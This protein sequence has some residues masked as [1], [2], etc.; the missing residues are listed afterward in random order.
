[1][2]CKSCALLAAILLLVTIVALPGQ[3][4]HTAALDR[5]SCNK[6]KTEQAALEKQGVRVT[7]LK[8]PEWAKTNLAADKLEQ[9][10]RVIELDEQLLFRCAG[11]H[12]VI[13]PPE[14]DPAA[15]APE[16]KE[17]E[18]AKQAEGKK[19]PAGKA[20]KAPKS[21]DK[22]GAAL[23][24]E[25]SP[26]ASPAKSEPKAEP[27]AETPEQAPPLPKEPQK[28]GAATPATPS[29]A[30]EAGDTPPAKAKPKAKAK[31]KPEADDAYKPADLF[32]LFSAPAQK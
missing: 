27:K 22:K 9:I 30:T 26:A 4:G 2:T 32:N 6:L 5:D 12:L 11:K 24:K 16:D 13:L 15:P 23:S 7:M 17:K 29:P 20:A 19:E 10:R 1:M 14:P 21:K 25:P 18:K 28:E 8:G 31:R 3:P